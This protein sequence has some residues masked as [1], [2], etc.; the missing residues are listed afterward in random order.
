MMIPEF[1]I[2]VYL[3]GSNVSIS[4]E[5]DRG[6]KVAEFIIYPDSK[7]SISNYSSKGKCIRRFV[8]RESLTSRQLFELINAWKDVEKN[9]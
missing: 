1:H 7:V 2:T 5:N 6:E 4:L 9:K 8:F 3:N